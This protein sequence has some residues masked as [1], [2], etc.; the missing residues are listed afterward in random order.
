MFLNLNYLFSEL[1]DHDCIRILNVN[2]I[3]IYSH[4]RKHERSS[5]L[6]TLTTRENS[7][8][9]P[10]HLRCNLFQTTE[11]HLLRVDP[12]QGVCIT[13]AEPRK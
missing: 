8:R 7:K 3:L 6:Q 2:T 13:P 12:H 1:E 9:L 10:Y 5:I 11:R 4:G